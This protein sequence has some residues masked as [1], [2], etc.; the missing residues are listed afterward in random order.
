MLNRSAAIAT[1][2]SD[3]HFLLRLEGDGNYKSYMRQG[4]W[5][6]PYQKPQPIESA[7][8][9]EQLTTIMQAGHGKPPNVKNLR[10]TIE[11][12]RSKLSRALGPD[13][14]T[15][16]VIGVPLYLSIQ[17][18]NE[19]HT[20]M[21]NAGFRVLSTV[22][23]PA[24]ASTLFNLHRPVVPGEDYT[25][26]V[27]DY[28]R[29]SLDLSV[30]PSANGASDVLAQQSFPNFGEDALDLQIASLMF[31]DTIE[32]RDWAPLSDLA[33]QIRLQRHRGFHNETD[34]REIRLHKSK[35][36]DLEGIKDNQ[37]RLKDLDFSAFTNPER[38]DF[39]RLVQAEDI[40]IAHFKGILYALD[41]FVN[42]HSY[43]AEPTARSA[44]MP[45]LTEKSNMLLS[46][47]ADNSGFQ[48]FRK[49]LDAS[50]IDWPLASQRESPVAGEVAAKGAAIEARA[51]MI[52]YDDAKRVRQCRD[53][54]LEDD[55]Q[56][57]KVKLVVP[58]DL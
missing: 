37:L 46:G 11:I 23:Q 39:F 50:D 32:G 49:M 19:I 57:S 54:L 58:H 53:R 20:E 33:W 6:R 31:N 27:V 36:F 28:N 35:P 55:Q 52:P 47:D 8:I 44:W 51:K 14:F 22:R 21:H 13:C 42:Q 3:I 41:E 5:D 18:R 30:T 10:P 38:L 40:E 16:I 15:N 1:D 25:T 48:A 56:K 7:N 29:A 45:R 24:L 26:F 9:N 43:N 2:K 34:G 17:S 12:L 4:L